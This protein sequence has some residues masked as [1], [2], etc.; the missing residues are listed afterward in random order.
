MLEKGLS[1]RG[2]IMLKNK[3]IFVSGGSGVIG[4]ELV[5]MLHE[6]G[7]I[8]YVGDLK[9]RPLDWPTEILYRQGDLNYISKAELDDFSPEIFF[10]LAASFERSLETYDFWEENFQNNVNLSHHLM[11]LLKDSPTLRKVIFASSYLIYDQNLYNFPTPPAAP[12]SLKETDP[13][14]PRNLTGCAKL[15]HEIELNFI[16][17]FKKDIQVILPR[18]YRSYGKNS[19]DIISRW[20]RSLLNEE[21]I[22]VY[23][24][25]DVFD[26]VY[27]GDVAEGLLRLS[28]TDYS[29]V[30][31]LAS[32]HSRPVSDVACVLYGYFPD[33][34]YLEIDAEKPFEASQADIGL[35][36]QITGWSPA[37]R[38]EDAIP[39]II[40]FEKTHTL[41]VPDVEPRIL[42]TSLSKKVPLAKA[43]ANAL[44]KLNQRG[45]LYGADVDSDCLGQYF[46]DSFWKMP[47]T[48]DSNLPA[49]LDYCF[50]NKI[51]SIIPTRDGELEF[52][53]RHK[54][55]IE[56]RG[57]HVMIS[58]LPAITATL[59]KLAFYEKCASLGFPAI[60]TSADIGRISSSELVVKEQFG[61]GSESI[62][63]GLSKEEALGHASKLDKP[64]FQPF[65]KGSE[66]SVDLYIDKTGKT[67]GAVSRERSLV[68]NGESQITVTIQDGK[69]EQ[70]CGALA[71]K[72][73]LYGHVILQVLVDEKHDFHIIECNARFGGAS[74]LSIAAGLD[75]FYW[76][77][78]ES[79]GVD[80]S[81]YPFLRSETQLKQVRF[82]VD[83]IVHES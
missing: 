25:E 45:T 39:K 28:E 41:P 31:N 15:N 55:E 36:R 70:L 74:T 35:L 49:I 33:M 75:S 18:I 22:Q 29:G 21:E 37:H 53:A 47:R 61:A 30:V 14:F 4:C 43:V 10:H 58:P 6:K 52:W 44:K 26:Y 60:P 23:H 54:E 17:E 56:S 79:A 16:N 8:L 78:L 7:A 20:V 42:I 71:E 57:I 76:F 59:D 40:E 81:S 13:I 72:L 63:L 2:M 66:V 68:V 82:P 5:R 67:K 38:L 51:T 48:T 62:G 80:I 46:V 11:T 24:K 50:E 3:R 65:I 1:I 83:I 34:K 77:L 19:R 73:G 64:I 69:L 9:P 27:A 12:R 32:G